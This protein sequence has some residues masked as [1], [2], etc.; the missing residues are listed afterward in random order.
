MTTKTKQDLFEQAIVRLATVLEDGLPMDLETDTI[1]A[2]TILM[3]IASV[4]IRRYE[5]QLAEHCLAED[6]SENMPIED[7]VALYESEACDFSNLDWVLKVS[8]MYVDRMGDSQVR[9]L[10]HTLVE[11]VKENEG[12]SDARSEND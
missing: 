7:L 12:R 9:C 6:K 5:A 8:G 4:R 3:T 11:H 2:A 10:L 1:S